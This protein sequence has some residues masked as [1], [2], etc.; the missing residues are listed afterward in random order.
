MADDDKSK[1]APSVGLRNTLR[2][3]VSFRVAGTTVRLS[4]QERR[5]VPEHWMGS[6]ELRRFCDSGMVTARPLSE[7]AAADAPETG[8]KDRKKPDRTEPR[9]PKPG[10]TRPDHDGD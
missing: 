8:R 4:P 9:H 6:A 10:R 5:E 7:A 2:R 1:S 3:P